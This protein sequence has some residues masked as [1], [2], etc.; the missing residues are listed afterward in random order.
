LSTNTAY[1]VVVQGLTSGGVAGPLSSASILYTLAA[2]PT[3]FALVQVG[4][5]SVALS[6]GADT[7]PVS[8]TSYKISYWQAAGSTSTLTVL[9]TTAAVTGLSGGATYYFRIS[10]VNGGGA[11]TDSRVTLSTTTLPASAAG[12]VSSGGGVVSFS[13]P[14]GPAT[15][16]IPPGAF[17]SAVNVTLSAPS[18][19]PGGGG[20]AAS[21][22]G[23]GVGIQI[24]LDQAVQPAVS[25]KLS[26][27]YRPG[28]VAGM[29]QSTLILARYDTT[30]NVWVPLVS[31]VDALDRIVTAQ[32]NHFS[33]F[34]IMSAAPSGT[35]ATA[36]A[37][38]NP[39]RP[40]LGQAY[41]TFSSLPASSRIRIYNL[42]GVL[43]KDMTADDSGM[44]NWD[45]T[46]Q[47]GAA[48]AS[49]V[50]FVFAQGAGQS[51]TLEVAV[52]R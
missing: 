9:T 48:V 44:A 27:S 35:V 41:M 39:L 51:R 24:E 2:P 45:A 47:S 46:N 7:N 26:V 22:A 32:T 33:T 38:P 20:P 21:L 6:W 13:A 16:T 30:Q 52:Q 50:Y 5:S 25:A 31:S 40:A 8:T 1:G 4:T 17:A 14:A 10:A 11:A 34:Q 19:F 15:V 23:T 49:G 28:D 12:N 18:S 42:K 29:D 43:I 3:G 36:K 37:F